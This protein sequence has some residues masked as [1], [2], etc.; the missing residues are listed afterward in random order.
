MFFVSPEIAPGIINTVVKKKD[1][2]EIVLVEPNV[3][4]FKEQI[5][6]LFI[7]LR[8]S[9]EF[10]LKSLMDLFVVDLLKK[11]DFPV[12]R[13]LVIYNLLS[14]K[15]NLRV[16]VKVLLKDKL[17]WESVSSIFS[18]ALYLEREVWDMFGIFFKE[19]PDLRRILTDYG[20]SRAS[21]T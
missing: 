14:V 2:I 3:V 9:E 11:T 13:F 7:F 16:S 15:K 1:Y 8:D 17:I 21:F 4:I 5:F 19:H 20:F 18:S 6:G 12:Y 10:Q